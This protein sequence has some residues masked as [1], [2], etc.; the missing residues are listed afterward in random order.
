MNGEIAA[1]TFD[2][3]DTL[4]TYRRDA[5][6]VLAAAFDRAGVEPLFRAAEYAD[7]YPDYLEASVDV[8]DLRR[9]CFAD[10]VAERG[11]DPAVGEAVADAYATERDQRA[12]DPLPGAREALDALA[13]RYA[14]ALVTNG[15]RSMQRAKLAGVGIDGAFDVAVFAGDETAPKPDPEPFEA[16]L[17][18]LDVDST[19]AIHVGNSLETDVAGAL[20]AGLRA[21]WVPDGDEPDG[22]PEPEPN[23]V[24]DSLADLET[25]PWE[26][27]PGRSRP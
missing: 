26:A 13:D 12:V 5:S 9:R 22:T 20:A 8:E 2:L 21:A 24:L 23:F 1:V 27:R 25:P 17:S 4:C 3:D 10:L 16:A 7:R 14:L 11:G 15:D 19:E 6:A 18:A